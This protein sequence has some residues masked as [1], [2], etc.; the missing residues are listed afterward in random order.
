MILSL[1]KCPISKS[2]ARVKSKSSSWKQHSHNDV[3][4]LLNDWFN[5][6]CDMLLYEA[7]PVTDAG[8]LRTFLVRDVFCKLR[9]EWCAVCLRGMLRDV[10]CKDDSNVYKHKNALTIPSGVARIKKKKKNIIMGMQNSFHTL[11]TVNSS[12]KFFFTSNHIIIMNP[13]GFTWVFF[14]KLILK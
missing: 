1:K 10:C 7:F 8:T 12:S 13:K 3:S 2:V 11:H 4:K 9:K 5:L 6:Q 14:Y